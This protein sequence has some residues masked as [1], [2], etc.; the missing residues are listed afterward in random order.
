[1]KIESPFP[2]SPEQELSIR[3]SADEVWRQT[4]AKEPG[5]QSEQAF[6]EG[7]YIGCAIGFAA[8]KA[9]SKIYRQRQYYLHIIIALLIPAVTA[10][11]F[12]K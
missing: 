9:T 8:V 2:F 12:Y 10:A 4:W 7:F 11:L 3:I 6:K 5:L 1:M